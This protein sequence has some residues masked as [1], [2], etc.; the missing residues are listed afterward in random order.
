MNVP[1]PP[2]PASAAP[3]AADANAPVRAQFVDA[4]RAAIDGR[5]LHRLQL[6]QYRGPEPDL[7]KLLIRAV[8]LRGELHL[9]L[10][11]RYKTRDITK[12]LPQAPA[13]ALLAELLAGGFD[14]AH[15]QTSTEDIQYVV[16]RKHRARLQ[17]GRLPPPADG[18]R[19]GP[20]AAAA[21]AALTELDRQK[22]RFV[23]IGKPFLVELGVT[24]AQQRLVPAMARKWKQINKFVEVLAH[25][26]D[27]AALPA[28]APL[29]VLDFGAGKGYLTFAVHDYLG[30]TLGRQL[31]V[32][33]VDLKDD[34]VKLGNEAAA[35]LGLEGLRFE[36]GDVRDYAQH[37][38]DIMIA[39]HACDVATDYAIHMGIRSG[40]S[41]IMCSPCCHKQLR[42]QMRSPLLLLP[43]LRHGIHLGQE[44][45]MLTDGLRALLLEAEGYETQVFEFTSLEHTSK[46]KMILALKRGATAERRAD[47]Q[48]QVQ[49]IKRFYGVQEQCLETLLATDAAGELASPA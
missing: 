38:V 12:N 8:T 9:S 13:L 44:A 2:Q 37:G 26:V 18:A 28:D 5:A 19:R 40:A 22:H 49:E 39:L 32:T 11:Y 17:R 16:N 33:G 1:T 36:H 35:K 48:A 6:G 3:E 20:A 47:L 24:D 15:L 46:N 43:L 45:E 23:A 31:Q 10:L 7:Q 14:H 4:V 27:S 21:P 41:I 34:M 30:A 25:A 29:R 42:P